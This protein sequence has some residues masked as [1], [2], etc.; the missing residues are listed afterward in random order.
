MKPTA[1]LLSL[2]LAAVMLIASLPSFAFADSTT[3]PALSGVTYSGSYYSSNGYSYSYLSGLSGT[4]LKTALHSLMTDT[5][6]TILSYDDIRTYTA[7]SDA[8]PNNSSKILLFYCGDSVSSTWDSGSTWN[9]EHVWCQSLGTF[10]TSGAGADLH[11]LRPTDPTINSKRGNKPFGN[12]DGGTAVYRSATN[13]LA[14]WYSS[15]YWE[16]TDDVKGDVAR[17]ILYVY[18]RYPA[19]T[20]LFNTDSSGSIFESL[21][22]MLDWMELD[23]VDAEEMRRN[24]AVE[25]IQ[26]NRNVFID[27]PE[28]AYLMFNQTPP[29]GGTS[30]TANPTA[31]PTAAPTAPVTEG[32][33]T[34]QLV[35]SQAQ[36]QAGKNYILVG[37]DSDNTY[38]AAGYQNTNNRPGV[39]VTPS[40]DYIT[41]A[42]ASDSTD[43]ASVYEFTLG[44]SSGAWTLYDSVNGGYLY[45]A[46][47]SSN[48]LRCQTANNADGQWTITFS[49]DAASIIANG[50]NTRNNLMFNRSANVFSC[51]ASGQSAVYLY[52]ETAT[53]QPTTEPTVQPTAEPTAEPTVEPTVEP[54]SAPESGSYVL[55]T[56]L[57]DITDGYYVIVGDNGTDMLAMNN[58]LTG[59][60]MGASSVTIS[61][62][63][64]VNPANELVWYFEETTVAD[65]FS[66]R[67]LASGKYVNISGTSTSGF[68]LTDSPSYYFNASSASAKAENAF[69]LATTASSGRVISIYQTDFR[70]YA[71]SSYKA[72]Y[73]YKLVSG[74]VVEPNTYTVTFKDWDGTVLSTQTVEEGAAATA[75]AAPSRTGYTFTGWD[76]D[77]SNVTSDLTV[78]AQYSVNSYTITYYVDGALYNTQTYAYG[79]AV[80]MLAEPTKEGYTF[81][82]WDTTITTMPANDVAVNGTFTLIPVTT[83]T[84]T[85][86]ANGEVVSTQNVQAGAAATAPAAPEVAGYHFVEWDTDYSNVQSDLVVTAVYTKGLTVMTPGAQVRTSPT[87]GIRFATTV[88]RDYDV[89]YIDI[90]SF[91]TLLMPTAM[92]GE[93]ELTL[94]TANVQNIESLGFSS[95]STE[96]RYVYFGSLL[97]LS[98]SMLSLEITARGYVY[99]TFGGEQFLAYAQTTVSRSYNGLLGA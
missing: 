14:G 15:N 32:E 23:P 74:G 67:S 65:Q 76:V 96:E 50:T 94:E 75:P 33:K 98:D 99:Y 69:Y 13:S 71:A 36:L 25:N 6:D 54:T 59:G 19:E 18:T 68:S 80:T 1:K 81:S 95:S 42:P 91:G 24:N 63:Y 66:I 30:P 35:T 97:G 26:G 45:A 48:Y 61:G 72:M 47:S 49:G 46:S 16:P 52:A 2:L 12:V 7:Q 88:A 70:S 4:T 60:K 27:Y 9:R 55:V 92:L 22:V 10:T 8:D 62:N 90:T 43:I 64:V 39:G 56:S 89:N 3:N 79:A 93:N 87:K 37:I 29:A 78:T 40:G 77:F 21:D 28:L 83:Y 34:Y 86:M 57:D 44:G 58:T 84:V 85:F 31:A 41:L 20:N 38:L 53:A 11:H 73:L 5:H 51:Y 82:G 17:I